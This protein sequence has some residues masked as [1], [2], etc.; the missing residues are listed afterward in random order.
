MNSVLAASA[1][2]PTMH[3][4]W[5]ARR[6]DIF[7]SAPAGQKKRHALRRASVIYYG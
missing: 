2:E 1:I 7:E 3:H 4:S 6:Y 5:G